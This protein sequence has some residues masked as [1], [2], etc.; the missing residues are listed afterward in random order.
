MLDDPKAERVAM[1]L[2]ERREGFD[3]RAADRREVDEILD[4][5]EVGGREIAL[6]HPETPARRPVHPSRPEE[7]AEL[8]PRHPVDPCHAV[9][10]RV[11][12]GRPRREGLRERL[13]G[14]LGRGFGVERSPG[15]VAEEILGV[16]PVQHGERAG[17]GRRHREELAIAAL[18]LHSGSDIGSETRSEVD[19]TRTMPRTEQV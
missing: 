8:V 18:V 7:P 11:P 9:R 10:S 15:E 13:G 14:E 1:I 16:A 12:V 4:P 19:S 5:L 2:P 6:R 3:D 17:L